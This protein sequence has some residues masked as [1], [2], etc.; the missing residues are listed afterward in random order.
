VK[1]SVTISAIFAAYCLFATSAHAALISYDFTGVGAGP[2]SGGGFNAA[3]SSY[4]ISGTF[5]FDDSLFAG[6]GFF[7]LPSPNNNADRLELEYPLAHIN[8]DRTNSGGTAHYETNPVVQ[9][10][11]RPDFRYADWDSTAT[12]VTFG[13]DNLIGFGGFINLTF[14][15]LATVDDPL[16]LIGLGGEA[17]HRTSGQ[18]GTNVFQLYDIEVT[19]ISAIPIPA[20]IWLFGTALIGL[21]GFSRRRKEV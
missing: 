12:G 10:T 11:A 13:Y 14:A 2:Q 19:G 8:F 9:V 18:I 7:R 21:V 17:L 16:D 15:G 5:T 20:A 4:S 3:D 1:S 6:T